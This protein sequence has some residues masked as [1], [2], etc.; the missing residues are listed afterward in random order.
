MDGKPLPGDLDFDTGLSELGVPSTDIAAF[1]KLVAEEFGIT[2]DPHA[3][4]VKTLRALVQ[5]VE[6]HTYGARN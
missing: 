3:C 6:A 1:G 5:G 4:A 2:L